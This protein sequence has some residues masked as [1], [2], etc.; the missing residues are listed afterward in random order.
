M[1]ESDVS[2]CA[3]RD[4]HVGTKVSGKNVS[5]SATC[6]NSKWST[7]DKFFLR[8]SED[9]IFKSARSDFP[10]FLDVTAYSGRCKS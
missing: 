2:E 6:G 8:S 5:G 3:K 1:G 4:C 7:S 9:L 10:V